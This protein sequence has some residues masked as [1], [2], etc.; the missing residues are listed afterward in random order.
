M[1]ISD[2]FTSGIG[3]RCVVDQTEVV[4]KQSGTEASNGRLDD[5]TIRELLLEGIRYQIDSTEPPEEQALFWWLL[6]MRMY[7]AD[8]AAAE[9]IWQVMIPDPERR[10]KLEGK[11]D[12]MAELMAE[13]Y[14]K[15]IYPG[16]S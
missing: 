13:L 10:A 5:D 15:E 9:R 11:M 3:G 7:A 1:T 8:M 12:R 2:R 16:Q 6:G 4:S 14:E